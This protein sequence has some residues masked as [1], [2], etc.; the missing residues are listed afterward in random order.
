MILQLHSKRWPRLVALR[1]DR[2]T[3]LVCALIAIAAYL[4]VAYWLKISYVPPFVSKVEPKVAGAKLLLH[5]PFV[6]FLNS[7]FSV[8]ASDNLFGGLADSVDNNERSPIEI[9]ENDKQLG[10]AHSQHADVARIGHGR[11]SIGET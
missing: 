8:I 9:Y 1:W 4:L 7:D 3:K 5:R 2:S 11:F 6:R 10:P